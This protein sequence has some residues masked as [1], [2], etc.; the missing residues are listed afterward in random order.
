MGRALQGAAAD[1]RQP[2]RHHA[3]WAVVPAIEIALKK[4]GKADRQSIRAAL[5]EVDVK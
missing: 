4:T 2:V 1:P 5:E 3:A